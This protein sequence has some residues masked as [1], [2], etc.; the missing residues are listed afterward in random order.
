MALFR[1]VDNGYGEIP[2]NSS[3]MSKRNCQT[4]DNRLRWHHNTTIR[5]ELESLFGKQQKPLAL[6]MVREVIADYRRRGK[7]LLQ[8]HFYIPEIEMAN[9]NLRLRLKKEFK[10]ELADLVAE[11]R[12]AE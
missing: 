6:A 9:S 1:I 12:G 4:L 11:Q 7:S 10:V 2:A 3:V 5:K 8:R